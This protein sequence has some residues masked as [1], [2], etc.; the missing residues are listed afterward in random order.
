MVKIQLLC[1]LDPRGRL[2]K[3]LYLAAELKMKLELLVLLVFLSLALLPP[4]EHHKIDHLSLI[5]PQLLPHQ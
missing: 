4:L 5:P 2:L 3:V 1:Q